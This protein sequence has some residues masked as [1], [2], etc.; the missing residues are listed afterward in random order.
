M[1]E[2]DVVSWTTIITGFAQHGSG[3]KALELFEKMQQV[4][5]QSIHVTFVGVL[6]T[7]NHSCLLDEG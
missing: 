3:K 6:T 7:C 1:I 4:G 5:I 2:Q